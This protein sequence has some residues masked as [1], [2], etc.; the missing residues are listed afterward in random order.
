[1]R[2]RSLGPVALFVLTAACGPAEQKPAS[3]PAASASATLT[4]TASAA[5]TSAPSASAAPSAAADVPS[6]PGRPVMRFWDYD[7]PAE[8]PAITGKRAWTVVPSGEAKDSFRHVFLSVEDFVRS[9]GTN[10]V[11][12]S[13]AGDIVA[14]VAMADNLAPPAKLQKGDPVFCE[15]SN[16]NA[17][18]RVDAVSGDT[19][20]VSSV[21][22]EM[23]G[24]ADAPRSEVVLLDGSLRF[25]APVAFKESA[26]WLVGRLIAKTATDAWIALE[27]TDN[28]PYAKAKL[29]DVRALDVTKILKVGDKVLADA[30]IVTR[31]ELVAA[32]VTKVI[33]GGVFYEVKM[34]KRPPL[35]IAFS[36]ITKPL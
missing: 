19:V 33:E 6:R 26:K 8:G 18:G 12:R 23:V 15:N 3:V 4:P 20:T 30:P 36:H 29:T 10:N 34:D 7:G 2:P 32:E 1:M 14:P 31:N 11:F 25:G 5:V 16:D 21:F 13:P 17:I 28:R 27:Y 24:E 9:D 35:K 22:G